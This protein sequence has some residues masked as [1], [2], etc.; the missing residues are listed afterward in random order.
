MNPKN[1]FFLVKV[2]ITIK[3]LHIRNNETM[4]RSLA[5]DINGKGPNPISFDALMWQDNKRKLGKIRLNNS[6]CYYLM[7]FETIL[8]L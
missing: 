8:K 1:S 3:V 4:K 5:L 6:T 2:K 7:N